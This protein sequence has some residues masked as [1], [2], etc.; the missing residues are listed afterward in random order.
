LSVLAGSTVVCSVDLVFA[1]GCF[2]FV[3]TVF[4]LF[5]LFGYVFQIGDY[6][7]GSFGLFVVIRKP[8]RVR[9]F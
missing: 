7:G 1:F 5:V 4:L 9:F 2:M 6:G 3:C 8:E